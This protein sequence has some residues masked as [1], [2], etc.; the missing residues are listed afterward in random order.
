MNS[1]AFFKRTLNQKPF[2]ERIKFVICSTTLILDPDADNHLQAF[3]P[4]VAR[5]EHGYVDAHNLDVSFVT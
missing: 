2:K 3:H 1:N 5:S 4:S